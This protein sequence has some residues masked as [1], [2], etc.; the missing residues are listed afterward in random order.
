VA[1]PF[2]IGDR[3]VMVPSCPIESEGVAPG[4]GDEGEI[5]APPPHTDGRRC[6]M[7]RFDRHHLPW[8]VPEQFLDTVHLRR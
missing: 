8:P 4:A 6:W 7:V 1:K 5:V 3:V 2:S